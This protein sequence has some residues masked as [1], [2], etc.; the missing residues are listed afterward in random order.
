MHH[1]AALEVVAQRVVWSLL[2]LLALLG[3]R[4]GLPALGQ[5]VRDPALRRALAA[6]ALL[7]GANWL[8]YI[9]AVNNHHILA[10][11]LGYFLN[12]LVNVALGMIFL[13]ERLRRG[14]AIAIGFAALG[15]AIMAASALQTL[16]ISVS[17][18]LTFGLYG[19]VRKVTPV[20]PMAGLATETLL[21][22][23]VALAYLGWAA[24]MGPGLSFGADAR[25]TVILVLLGA[26]TTVPL[27]LFATAAQ[28][29]PLALLGLLQYLAPTLQFLCGVLLFGETLSHAQLASFGLIWL[30]LLLFAGDGIAAARRSR[31]A[32]AA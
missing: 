7:I 8:I 20:A 12:P 3:A 6:S 10:G 11:S 17:L 2:L 24:L 19:L 27:V 32:P 28:R 25:T 14:Q 5:A 21:L 23:P 18:A 29:L 16:W 9:W 30:G 31:L 22:M 15:V 13:G 26:I 1:V 4:R